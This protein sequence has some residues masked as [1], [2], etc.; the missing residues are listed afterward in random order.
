MICLSRREVLAQVGARRRREGDVGAP[1]A[2]AVG[3]ELLGR[4]PG[5]VV[6]ARL[7]PAGR[8]GVAGLPGAARWLSVVAAGL[9]LRDEAL[10]RLVVARVEAVL[11]LHRDRVRTAVELAVMSAIWPRRQASLSPSRTRLAVG[12]ERAVDPDRGLV[13]GREQDPGA[14]GALGRFSVARRKR[15]FGPLLPSASSFVYQTHLAPLKFRSS[16]GA[17]IHLAAKSSFDSRPVSSVVGALQ[18]PAWPVSSHART[19]QVYFVPDV[20]AGRRTRRWRRGGV[21]LT[22][23]PDRLVALGDAIW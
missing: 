5:A 1:R 16:A 6:E 10:G 15:V 3:R 2:A 8:L 18:S 23:V 19:F 22:A 11:D 13:V 9:D 21:H 4:R 17:A 14:A 20:R 12:H 7:L